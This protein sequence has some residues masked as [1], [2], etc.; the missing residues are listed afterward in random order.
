[1]PRVGLLILGSRAVSEQW[2]APFHAKLK[3]QGWV[4]G[5][6][7]AF[8]IRAVESDAKGLIDAAADLVDLKVDV[9]FPVGP[10]AVRAAFAA[11]R[12]IPIVA[13]D[14]ETDPV[15]AGY[16]QSY[17]RPGKNLTGLFL[18]APELAAKWVQLLKAMVPRLA[19]IAVVWD[20]SS[21]TVSLNAVTSAAKVLG[22]A[23]QVYEVR[24]PTD[25]EKV[26]A[27]A[28]GPSQAMIVLPSAMLWFQ[29]ARLAELVTKHLIPAT[30]MFENFAEKGGLL[31]YGPNMAATAEQCGAIVAKILGGAK[32]GDLPI[33]RPTKFDFLVNAKAAK[34]LGLAVP[35]TLLVGADKVIN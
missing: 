7:V 27:M 12:D 26:P 20:P 23:T 3:E 18:D 30:S 16:A 5:K 9:L 2:M 34:V 13:H 8:E 22:V 25:V 28:K 6:N 33:E 11:T 10:P 1:M 21:G 32:A 15:A 14:F 4:E 19:R 17:G 24:T 31:A 29:S 35:D